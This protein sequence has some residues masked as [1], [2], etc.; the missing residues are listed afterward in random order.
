MRIE[1]LENISIDD[2]KVLQKKYMEI[3]KDFKKFCEH[4][5]LK[6]FLIGGSCIG[7]LRHQGIIPW[8]DDIDVMLCREDYE[9]LHILWEKYGDKEKYT[10]CRTDIDNNYHQTTSMFKLNSST[11][12][13]QHSKDEDIHHG[14]YIDVDVLDYRAKGKINFLIQ[15]F[16]ASLYSIFNV[17]R[18]PDNQGKIVRMMTNIILKS[19]PSK[20]IRHKIW[21]YALQKMIDY[22]DKNSGYFVELIAGPKSMMRKLPYE[23]FETTKK[24][25][26]EDDEMPVPY[27]AEK[28]MSLIFGNYM[29]FPPI[30][31]R[32]AKHQIIFIDTEIPYK[33]YK[34]KY[35]CKRLDNE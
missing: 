25:K 8:D 32:K 13:N 21:R 26:F 19:V 34:G 3:L 9:K 5:D 2:L 18:L 6:F 17:Q 30:E 20:K 10:L 16:Y 7:A 4:H 12:I 23:W 22:G 31:E 29:E 28:W 1:S 14:L 24:M 33:Y 35:Y 11:Y 27:G 15:C